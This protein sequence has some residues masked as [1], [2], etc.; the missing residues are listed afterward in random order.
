MRGERLSP[1]SVSAIVAWFVGVLGGAYA[2]FNIAAHVWGEDVRMPWLPPQVNTIILTALGIAF[3]T[4]WQTYLRARDFARSEALAV[5]RHRTI[6]A[7]LVQLGANLADNTGELRRLQG[8]AYEFIDPSTTRLIAEIDR[9]MR[10]L[11]PD[12]Q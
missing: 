7:G 5:E 10:H 3:L 12:G 6:K 8:G 2:L 4:A 1:Q 11:R 9:D